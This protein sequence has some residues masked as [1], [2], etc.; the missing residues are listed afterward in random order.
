MVSLCRSTDSF[1]NYDIQWPVIQNK[2]SYERVHFILLYV[3]KLKSPNITYAFSIFT[4]KCFIYN[5]NYMGRKL[6]HNFTEGY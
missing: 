6:R 3:F 5:H 1:A 4:K 2:A